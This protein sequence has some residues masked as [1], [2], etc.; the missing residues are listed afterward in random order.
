M[1]SRPKI[2][3][4]LFASRN[5]APNTVIINHDRYIEFT[6]LSESVITGL[7]F[8]PTGEYM[9]TIDEEGACLIS[10]V[11]TNNYKFHQGVG[12]TGGKFDS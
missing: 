7:D 4:S 12:R 5:G 6:I 8:N 3:S 10:N 1:P 2:L 11:T 9:A